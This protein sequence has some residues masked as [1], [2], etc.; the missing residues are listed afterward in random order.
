DDLPAATRR[1]YQ[2]AEPGDTVLLSP[3]C[4]SYDMFEGYAHR[5]QVFIDTV[6]GL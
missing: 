1:A 4:A 5:A 6:R 2:M 3:A